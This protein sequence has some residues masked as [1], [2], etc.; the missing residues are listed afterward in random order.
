MAACV[1]EWG[2]SGPVESVGKKLRGTFVVPAHREAATIART[3]REL[4]ELA[5]H[6]SEFRWE[7]VIVDDGSDDDT[8]AIALET[9]NDVVIP[10]K[11][12]RHRVNSGLGA[13]LRTG[14][15]SSHG[16]LVVTV[17]CDLSYSVADLD[18][19]ITAWLEHRP[20]IVIASPY[21]PGGRTVEVPK[22]L[23]IRS[24]QANKFLSKCAYHD[25]KTLT[26][27]VRAYDGPFIRSLSLKAEGADIMVEILYKA[28]VLRAR[29]E[30]IPATL[31]WAGM[32]ERR[33]RSSLSSPR[34]RMM[35]YRSIIQG[36]LWVAYWVPLVPG[37]LM[38]LLAV[39]LTA[40]GHLGWHGLAVVSALAAV[41][42]PFLSLS[43]L[44]NKR[45]F[46]ELFNVGFGLR[47]VNE[48]E[49]AR[50]PVE[51]LLSNEG[52][53]RS[54]DLSAPDP[55]LMDG[56]PQPSEAQGP[57]PMR[58]ERQPSRP[59]SSVISSS[60]IRPLSDQPEC[61]HQGSSIPDPITSGSIP[62]VAGPRPATKNRPRQE[63]TIPPHT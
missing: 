28:Q 12:L 59:R 22:A 42:L 58:Y 35:T 5:S 26:G 2:E 11:L 8:S 10:I 56:L 39:V 52:T 60:V 27:M 20:H 49:P 53:E 61:K 46:E 1:T 47:Q 31:S 14:I 50:A 21:M 23:E 17:D 30:E 3:I 44:Q 6:R 34:S 36:Y 13:A 19:L 9:A 55:L 25:V 43:S 57:E 38:G 16:D 51:V 54:V 63:R 32:G 15:S 45:Y 24:R 37:V 18:R 41:L 4:A 29:I 33:Q 48:T 62:R 40:T 7:L